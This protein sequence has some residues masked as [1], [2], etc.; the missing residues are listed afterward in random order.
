MHRVNVFEDRILRVV[1]RK[2]K[3]GEKKKSPNTMQALCM[4]VPTKC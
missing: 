4:P 2:K 1:R 3:M